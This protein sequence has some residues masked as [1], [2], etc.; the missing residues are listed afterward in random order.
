MFASIIGWIPA[1]ILPTATA[2]QLYKLIKDKNSDGLSSLSWF[3]FALAN[4]GLYIFT[5]KYFEIQAILAL[6]LTTI[7]DIC[8]VIGIRFYKKKSHKIKPY[9]K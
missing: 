4:G 5:E 1:V 8:I 2:I 7:L 3:F 6:L 9:K